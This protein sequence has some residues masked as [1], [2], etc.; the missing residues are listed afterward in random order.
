MAQEGKLERSVHL[1]RAERVDAKDVDGRKMERRRG[2]DGGRER[3]GTL[4]QPEPLLRPLEDVVR[5]N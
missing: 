2:G 1:E 3:K 5:S 4:P